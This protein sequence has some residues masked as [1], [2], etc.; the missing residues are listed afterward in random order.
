LGTIRCGTSGKQIATVL[1]EC[2]RTARS[3]G[4][5]RGLIAM[6]MPP[7]PSL[8]LPP[9]AP[10]GLFRP[11]VP[12]SKKLVRQDYVHLRPAGRHRL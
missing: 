1:A 11:H 9:A 8:A 6:P 3:S 7:R 2:P 12:P 4:L 5:I 10:P